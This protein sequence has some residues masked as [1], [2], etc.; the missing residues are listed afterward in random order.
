MNLVNAALLGVGIFALLKSG[1]SRPV[2]V[3]G[4][5]VWSTEQKALAGQKAQMIGVKLIMLGRFATASSPNVLLQVNTLNPQVAVLITDL[6][7]AVFAFFDR[8]KQFYRATG[9]TWTR[10]LSLERYIYQ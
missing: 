3:P 10:D 5:T 2:D 6:A 8:P 1:E 9:N 4:Q 7:V